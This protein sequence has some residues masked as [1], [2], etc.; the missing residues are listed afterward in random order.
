M[1]RKLCITSADGQTGHLVAELILTDPNFSSKIAELTCLTLH[2]EKCKDLAEQGAVVVPF[3]P[4]DHKGLVASLKKSGAD[5]IFVIPPAHKDKVKLAKEM[6]M[7]TR[8]AGVKN[9]VLLSSAACDLAEVDVQPRLREFVDIEALFMESKGLDTTDAGHSPCIIRAGFYAENLLLY[10]KDVKKNSKLRLP[11]GETHKFA[12]V[13]LGDIAQIA[14]HVLTGEGPQG[15]DDRHRGQ[16]ITMTGP[17]MTSGTEL[18]EAAKQA[19]LNLE[20]EDIQEEEAKEL[21]DSDTTLDP[22]EKEYL[23]E[24]YS[25]VRE[26]KANY[27]STLAFRAITGED[28][29][30]PVEFFKTYDA[31]FKPK[32]RKLRK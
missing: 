25:L 23:L 7:A 11:I 31:E 32:R 19:G 15:L 28:A 30:L 13:A 6:I 8:E 1:S 16:L 9:A 14:A 4:R 10:D 29:T 20:F 18:A 27:V 17:M 3:K 21:L 22:S 24:Y 26:G 12:P 2:P 5:T